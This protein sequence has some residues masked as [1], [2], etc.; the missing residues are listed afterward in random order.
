M[1]IYLKN[2]VCQGTRKFVLSEVK[3]MGLELK[4]F[5]SG[6]IEFGKDLSVDQEHQLEFRL[7]NYG[8][9]ILV[10]RDNRLQIMPA[11]SG[12]DHISEYEYVLD[13][14]EAE[15]LTEVTLGM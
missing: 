13:K 14:T 11:Y 7:K 8:L 9:E 1:K 10:D 12:T 4:S 2:M 15:Q 6:S 3:K 5:E